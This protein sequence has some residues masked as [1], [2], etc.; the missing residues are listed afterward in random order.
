[1]DRVM[2]VRQL[3]QGFDSHQ[4]SIAQVSGKPPTRQLQVLTLRATGQLLM[5]LLM[6]LLYN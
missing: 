3:G 6:K 4:W 1:M 5:N 2:D